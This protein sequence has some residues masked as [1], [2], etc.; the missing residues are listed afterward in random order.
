L[1]NRIVKVMSAFAA[2][3]EMPVTFYMCLPKNGR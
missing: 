1:F 3:A 2:G